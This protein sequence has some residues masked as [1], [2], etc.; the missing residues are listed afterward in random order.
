MGDDVGDGEG[1]AAPAARGTT[2]SAIAA[3][4]IHIGRLMST[5]GASGAV[6]SIGVPRD[7]ALEGVHRRQ[8]RRDRLVKRSIRSMDSRMWAR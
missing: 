5:S 8:E 3:I 1:D 7:L 4:V 2:R 6:R